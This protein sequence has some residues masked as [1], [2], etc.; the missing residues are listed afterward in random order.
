M[1]P[2][3]LN[4]IA[5]TVFLFTMSALLGPL[6]NLSPTVPAVAVAG[7]LGLVT[8]DTLGWQGRGLEILLDAIAGTSE[9]RR[10]RVTRHEAG[11]FLVAHLL[12]VPISGYTLSAWEAFRQG[13][14]GRGGVQFDDRQLL[15]QLQQG[16]ISDRLLNRYATIWMAGIAAETLAYG[17]AEGGDDDLLQLRGVLTQLRPAISDIS[18]RE[19]WAIL[20][21]KTLIESNSQAYDRLVE[22]MKNRLPV[23]ECQKAISEE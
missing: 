8:I 5:I 18:A 7:L 20:Q 17:S 12:E 22:A 10:L 2:I 15:E 9:E 1:N 14:K 23:A 16:Q 21:A 6:I 3:S 13:Q 19:R 4:L 11:H